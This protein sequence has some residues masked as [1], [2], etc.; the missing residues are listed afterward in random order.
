MN[1]SMNVPLVVK[2][3]MMMNADIATEGPASQSHHET[4]R[5]PF[6]VSAVGARRRRRRAPSRMCRSPLGS[7]NQLGPSMPTRARIALTTPVVEKR[8]SH[9]TVI[10]TEL[11]T[12]GK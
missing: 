6:R 1:S 9:S 7:L 2:I 10:A 5:K 8:N 12:D 11:V 4:P 3:A